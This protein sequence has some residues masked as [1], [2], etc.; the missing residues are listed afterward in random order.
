M[1]STAATQRRRG[2]NSEPELGEHGPC[3]GPRS[4]RVGARPVSEGRPCGRVLKPCIT[5][6]T[7]QRQVTAEEKRSFR[8]HGPELGSCSRPAKFPRVSLTFRGYG[9]LFCT[10]R[11]ITPAQEFGQ[12]RDPRPSFESPRFV[13]Q[14]LFQIKMVSHGE[15]K[16]I[17][18]KS[19]TKDKYLYQV[20]KHTIKYHI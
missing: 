13:C 1:R 15:K 8:P 19:I 18:R 16:N 6:R 9:S 5:V 20:L 12:A 2:R 17:L 14:L 11:V 3:A 7:S 4:A 10:S